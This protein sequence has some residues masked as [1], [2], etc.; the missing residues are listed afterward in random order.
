MVKFLGGPNDYQKEPFAN[1]SFYLEVDGLTE[2]V[3]REASGIGS[4]SEVVESRQTTKEGKTIISKSPGN[5]KWDDLSLKRGF[6]TDT[7]LYDWRMLIEQGKV[8]DARKN[9]SLT[10]YA[11]D[12]TALAKWSFINGWPSKLSGPSLNATANEV[13]VEE[14]TIVHEGLTREKM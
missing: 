8:K 12:G 10:V 7:K 3:F 13:A 9:G 4:T 6:T 11:S 1:Y 14:I 2:A 5:L